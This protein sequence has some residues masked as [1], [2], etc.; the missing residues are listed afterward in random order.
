MRWGR[1]DCF[2]GADG[3]TITQEINN[4]AQTIPMYGATSN[5][6]AEGSK[7][8][9]QLI[10]VSTSGVIG[11]DNTSFTYAIKNPLGFIYSTSDWYTNNT[12]YQNN[13]LWSTLKSAYDPCP[14]GWQVPQN[15]IWSD[16]STTTTLLYI[17]GIQSTSGSYLYATN[18]RL[19]GGFAWYPLSGQRVS[20]LGTVSV[21]GSSGYSWSVTTTGTVAYALAYY[22]SD[23]V[24]DNVGRRAFGFPVRCVQE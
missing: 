13:N 18:G 14:K 3:S 16:F 22:L 9:L 1:K 19:Y 11:S 21:I 24:V 23:K 17:Q 8:G 12:K 2:P 4:N 7:E 10:D 15:G 20:N 5:E 6:L